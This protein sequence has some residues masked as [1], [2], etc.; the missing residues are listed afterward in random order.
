MDRGWMSTSYTD[1]GHIR[2]VYDSEAVKQP[3]DRQAI[4]EANIN[5][6]VYRIVLLR[7][8]VGRVFFACVEVD[9]PAQKVLDAFRLFSYVMPCGV[10]EP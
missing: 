3:E 2:A 5:I 10:Q 8:R 6:R 7:D 1:A 9:A 4:F